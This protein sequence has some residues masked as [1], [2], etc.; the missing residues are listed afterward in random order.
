VTPELSPLMRW[1]LAVL[2]GGGAAGVVHGSTALL[3][4]KSSAF[5]AGLGNA[6][7]ATGELLGS[8]ALGLLGLIAPL[9]AVAVVVLL[10]VAVT[11]RF[12]A[13]RDTRPPAG[14]V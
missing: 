2:I 11:R 4:L 9:V 1:T 8:L 10:L 5:T 7:I 12:M 6:G 3:R 13:R 14:L